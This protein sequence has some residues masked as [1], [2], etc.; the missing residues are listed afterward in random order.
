MKREHTGTLERHCNSP[1]DS[2]WFKMKGEK[3]VH[4]K[5]H[6]NYGAVV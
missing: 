1:M 5:G 3:N 6:Y 2:T 4:L